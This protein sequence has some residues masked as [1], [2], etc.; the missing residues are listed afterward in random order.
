M[1]RSLARAP[2][3]RRR[4]LK[5]QTTSCIFI[6]LHSFLHKRRSKLNWVEGSAEAD[7]QGRG[8]RAVGRIS[9]LHD[10][11]AE[12]LTKCGFC[13][14]QP[15]S[16]VLDA[17]ECRRGLRAEDLE[18]ARVVLV[19]HSIVISSG[20]AGSVLV[21]PRVWNI[22]SL[23]WDYHYDIDLCRATRS[24]PLLSYAKQ[25]A[26]L[27]KRNFRPRATKSGRDDAFA[28]GWNIRACTYPRSPQIMTGIRRESARE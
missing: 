10:T 4:H 19:R 25:P 28:C 21:R 3:G 7:N 24:G 15:A 26:T 9:E 8:K 22:A 5:E 13:R 20:S 11:N 2:L 6:S 17:L 27:I 16:G 12:F 18:L 14:A 1:A 23:K